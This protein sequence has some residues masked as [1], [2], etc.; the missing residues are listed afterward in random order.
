MDPFI[1]LMKLSG[2]LCKVQKE[3]QESS[4]FL[5]VWPVLQCN[6]SI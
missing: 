4:N 1:V 6:F 2:A 3:K 5:D